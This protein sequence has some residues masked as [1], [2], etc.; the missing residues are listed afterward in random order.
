MILE[1]TVPGNYF[2]FGGINSAD[3]G[4][5]I[6]GTATF[7]SPVKDIG[8]VTIPG[9]SGNVIFD[10][11]RFDNLDI[12]YHCFIPR[13]FVE[14]FDDFKAALMSKTG[15]QR[16]E[17]T[18]QP[19]YF[20]RGYIVGPIQPLTGALNR[21]ASFDVT[22]TCKPQR[23]LKLG[24]RALTLN[25]TTPGPGTKNI[26]NRTLYYSKPLIQVRSA[27][28]GTGTIE[29]HRKDATNADDYY[30]VTINDNLTGTM[31]LDSETGNAYYEST[32]T[33][34][35]RKLAMNNK[36]LTNI[37]GFPQIAPGFNQVVVTGDITRLAI[38]PRWYTI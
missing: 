25:Y 21:S 7:D 37:N 35:V 6:S 13:G 28:H 24:E 1:P 20:R 15:Y 26:H 11:K 29:I 17:D 16:L 2:V 14:K 19:D 30:S 33:G 4:V 23:Y 18:F 12:V 34:T 36:I 31:Y 10:N 38:Q 32:S 8:V 3:Y 9:R 27:A 22:F 5:F